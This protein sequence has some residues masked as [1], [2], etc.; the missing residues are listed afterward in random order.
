MPEGSSP[1]PRQAAAR[2]CR[3]GARL[4]SDNPGRLCATCARQ[5]QEA[6]AH[7]PEIPPAYWQTDQLRDALAS[8][9]LGRVVRA[10]RHHP[11]HGPRPLP[12]EQVAGWLGITQAQLSRIENGPPVRDLDRLV[13]W[14]RLL[15]IPGELLWFD[16]PGARTAPA[17]SG[18][19]LPG[20]EWT[21][22]STGQLLEALDSAAAD[23]T[24]ALAA[25]L[26]H[27]WL[28]AEPPQVVEVRAGRRIGADLLGRVEQRVEYL[29]RL[30][31]FLGGGDSYALVRRELDVTARLL[32]G[33]AYSEQLGRRLL[34]TVGELS[35]VAG[36]IAVDADQHAAAVRHYATGIRAAH[37]AGDAPLA[38]NLVSLLSYLY[39]NHGNPFEAALLAHTA[40][41]GAERSAPA[42]VRA[43]LAERVAWAHARAGELRQSERALGQV[44]RAFDARRPEDDPGWVYWLD[45]DEVDVMAG[46][47]YT[48]LGQPRRAGPLLRRVLARYDERRAREV[49]LYVSWLAQ[50]HI[51]AGELDEAAR[52]ASRA[53]LA[54]ASVNTARGNERVRFLR[55]QLQPHAGVPAVRD[56]EALYL[57]LSG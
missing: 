50:G 35:Q 18:R 12:Q 51:Q 48:E 19:L 47:C 27:E 2:Y 52:Q 31:D 56:F 22:A 23:V 24:P 15:G 29:R 42:T 4:A 11:H 32:G 36:W 25:R 53:L 54:A 28:I 46:R 49:A 14:A 21:P 16:L 38:A 17:P 39:A 34:R 26:A 3:C 20:G 55:H 8:R 10:W 44:D 9:H 1:P 37:A 57:E 41:S 7:P 30:D 13:H 45:A 5:A 6:A 43:L 33:A 40:A